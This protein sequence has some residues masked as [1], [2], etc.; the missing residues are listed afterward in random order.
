MQDA[1]HS[2]A[3]PEVLAY[4]AIEQLANSKCLS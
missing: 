1:L 3:P 4:F 2:V